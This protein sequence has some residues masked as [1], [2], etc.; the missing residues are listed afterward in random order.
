MWAVARWYTQFGLMAGT[1]FREVL[2]DLR[3]EGLAEE[4]GAVRGVR[5]QALCGN[6]VLL[7]DMGLVRGVMP[8]G[9]VTALASCSL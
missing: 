5:G 7:D 8:L 9:R 3:R 1:V 4:A 2:D 6:A